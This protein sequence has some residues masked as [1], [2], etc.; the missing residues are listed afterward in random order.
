[1]KNG[2]EYNDAIHYYYNRM[3]RVTG[4]SHIPDLLVGEGEEEMGIKKAFGEFLLWFLR[5]RYLRY[6]LTEGKM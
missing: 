1:M 2:C 4:P 5:E 6:L 3:E